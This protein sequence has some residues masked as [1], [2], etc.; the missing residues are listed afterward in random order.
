MPESKILA[1]L[2][3]AV[4][5]LSVETVAASAASPRGQQPTLAELVEMTAIRPVP[6]KPG[7]FVIP[8]YAATSAIPASTFYRRWS[9]YS[10]AGHPCV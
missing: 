2:S 7:L 3:V 8:G 10:V 1:G 5:V 6:G 4:L 9:S